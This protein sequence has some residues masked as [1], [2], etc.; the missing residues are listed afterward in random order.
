MSKTLD[1]LKTIA[2]FAAPVVGDLITGSQ[3][4]RNNEKL[5]G[6]QYMYGQKAAEQAYQRQRELTHDSWLLNKQGM[7]AAGINPAFVDGASNN[8]ASVQASDVPSNPTVNAPDYGAALSQ[9]VQ[10]LLTTTQVQ[11]DNRLKNAQARNQEIKNDFEIDNQLSNLR[12]QLDDHK[13]SQAEYDT[14]VEELTRLRD[15]HDSYVKQEDEKANQAELDTKIKEIQVKQENSKNEI[16]GIIKQLNEEQLK[17]AKFITEHQLEQYISDCA[18]QASRIRAN[19]A[20]AAASFASAAASRAQAML[21]NIQSK[22]ENA[23]VPYAA[24]LAKA[25]S[26]QAKYAATLTFNQAF[27]AGLDNAPKAREAQYQN[28]VKRQEGS[29]IGRNIFYNMRGVF[30]NSLG[31]VFKFAK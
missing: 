10:N 25:L 28:Y 24:E 9:G 29:W 7:V 27:G 5:M 31:N 30:D 17:Q 8:V 21:T 23:K 4:M 16:L 14:R 20:S 13:I 6:I 1:A 12:K 3:S 15:T 18:E 19:D 22:L 2:G 26:N 11:A